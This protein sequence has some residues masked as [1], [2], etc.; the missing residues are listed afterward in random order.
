L[1]ERYSNIVPDFNQWQKDSKIM[2]KV[3]IADIL[4]QVPYTYN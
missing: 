3:A 1:I 4:K 2:R